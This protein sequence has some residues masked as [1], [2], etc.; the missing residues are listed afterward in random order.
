MR[1]VV[2]AHHDDD[3]DDDGGDKGV[4]LRGACV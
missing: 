3:D 2:P 1:K 4:N